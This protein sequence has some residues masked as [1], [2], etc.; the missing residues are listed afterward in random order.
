VLRYRRQKTGVLATVKLPE[1][2]L[3]ALRSVPLEKGCTADRPFRTKDTRQGSNVEKWG[4]RLKQVFNMASITEVRTDFRVRKPHM[5]MFRDTAAV[6]WLRHYVPVHSVSKALGHAS[7][8]TTER[9]YLPWVKELEDSHIE[10][11]DK[12]MAA[13]APAQSG[14]VL[15]F[16]NQKRRKR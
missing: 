12:V 9:A 4:L 11:M 6:W 3:V 1:H 7:V 10:A 13:A 8:T 2:V 15:T 14:K 5:K 16:M